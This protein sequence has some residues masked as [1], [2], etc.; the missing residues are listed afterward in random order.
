[1]SKEE[2]LKRDIF[3]TY[4][5]D[6]YINSNIKIYLSKILNVDKTC[7]TLTGYGKAKKLKN[8]LPDNSFN[9]KSF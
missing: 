7:T 9:Q 4:N 8:I 2:P 1:V 3:P 6:L 5:C